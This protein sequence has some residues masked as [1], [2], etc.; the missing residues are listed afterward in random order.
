MDVALQERGLS[1]AAVVNSEE[2]LFCLFYNNKI[3]LRWISCG[4][5]WVVGYR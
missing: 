4:F 1:Y 5:N 2:S 3:P